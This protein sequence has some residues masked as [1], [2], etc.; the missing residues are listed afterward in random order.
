[1]IVVQVYVIFQATIRG[2]DYLGAQPAAASGLARAERDALF[3]LGLTFWGIV[4]LV[5]ASVFLVGAGFRWWSWI[6]TAHLVI[7][8]AYFVV[9]WGLF[10]AAF[11]NHYWQGIR[12]P[13]GLL[14][15]V[16][17]HCVLAIGTAALARQSKIRQQGGLGAVE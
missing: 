16:L 3:G 7:A 1:M 10:G 13:S 14:G 17:L 9:S 2:L 12:T 4:F 11:V 8:A 5:G 15:A 6:V